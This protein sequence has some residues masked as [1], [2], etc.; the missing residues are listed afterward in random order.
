M[1][2]DDG[3]YL[4]LQPQGLGNYELY[5]ADVSALKAAATVLSQE[6][7]RLLSRLVSC[8]ERF[9]ER[10]RTFPACGL[11]LQNCHHVA[12]PVAFLEFLG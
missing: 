4:S 9:W 12:S 10:E 5:R 3:L 7:M 2:S 8:I 1:W 6:W 11:S